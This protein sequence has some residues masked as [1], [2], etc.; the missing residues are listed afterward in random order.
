[1][2]LK[3]DPK[4]K[5]SPSELRILALLDSEFVSSADLVARYYASDKVPFH[6]RK[7]VTG[8]LDVLA[9]KMVANGEECLVERTSSRPMHVRLKSRRRK[10]DE[11]RNDRSSD[12]A[13]G[14][15]RH[16]EL[17]RSEDRRRA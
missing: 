17:K 15:R 4:V 1:M 8:T 6:G 14:V 12:D 2:R 3:E 13:G 5:Y 9:R 11:I 16:R 7:I 10:K